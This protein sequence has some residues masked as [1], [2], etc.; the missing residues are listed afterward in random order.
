MR[1]SCLTTISA[2]SLCEAEVKLASDTTLIPSVKM[3]VEARTQVRRNG[4]LEDAAITSKNHPLRTGDWGMD[5][6]FRK[7][8]ANGRERR[9]G[10]GVGVVPVE[11]W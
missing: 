10:S 2:L 8:L 9:G 6:V 5:R 3:G 1:R 11:N 4:G 7:R